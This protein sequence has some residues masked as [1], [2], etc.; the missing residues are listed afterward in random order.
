MQNK[1]VVRVLAI[2]LALVSLFY[3]SFSVVTGYYSNKAVEYAGGNKMKEYQYL[4][5]LS[6]E[7]VYLGYTLKECRE[8]EINLGLDLKGGMN[9]TL[10]VSV[11]D[12]LRVLSGYNNSPE[13]VQALQKTSELQKT[14]SQQD[15]LDLFVKTFEEIN[16]GG[17]L[18]SVFS[19][20]E[21]KEQ[22]SLKS[23]NAEVI[24]VLRGEIDAAISNS[25]NVLRTRIDRFGVVQPNIQRDNNNV[26]RIIIELPGVKEP[27][28]VRKLLQGSAN[29]EFWETFDLIEI[30]NNLME[31][32]KILAS[33]SVVKDTTAAVVADKAAEAKPKAPVT[34]QD[35]LKA[36]LKKDKAVETDSVKL[37]Q[38][39]KK[40]HPLLAVL[41]IPGI[42]TGQ[43]SRGPV[44]GYA[45]YKDTA[46]I[47]AYF[48]QRAVKEVLPANLALKWTVKPINERGDIYQLIAIKT[49]RN[50]R[51]PLTGESV[52]DARADFAQTS[53]YANVSMSMNNEGAKIWGR[54]TKENI[55]K[56]IAI[57]LDGYIYSFPTVNGE[58]TGGQSQITGN[59]TV[60]EAKDLANTLKSGKMP[61]PA[62]IIQEDVVGPTLG[63]DAINSGLISFLIA[64]LVVLAYMMF[65]YGFIPGLI[66][67]IALF[68]NVFF[69]I[70]ILASFSAVLTLPGIAGIVLTL[71][72][73][74]DGNVLIY[75]RIK[76]E[77]KGGKTMKKAIE[78]GFKG[79]ISAIIDANVT[80]LITGIVLAVF[81]TGP[82]K[83][84]ANTLIIG[85]ITSF[86]T[87]VFLTRLM[88]E[89]YA[90]KNKAKDLPFSTSI[91][92]GWFQNA[93]LNFL[94]GRRVAYII[95]GTLIAISLVS[96]FTKGFSLG[97]DFSGGRNYIVRFDENVKPENVRSLL[98]D[99]FDGTPVTVITIGDENQ[100][101]ITTKYKIDDNSEKVDAEIEGLLYEGL[102]PLLKNT[103]KQTFVDSNIMSSQKVGPTIAD[104]I[105]RAAVWAILFSILAIGL[106]I[107]MRFR[108]VSY[109][110]GAVVA[111]AHDAII[112][113][114][115]FS[116]LWDILPFS[117]EIDQ[118]FIAAILTVIGYS[119]NDTV[120]VFDRIRE[121][122]KLYPKRD[123]MTI[124]N[125]A[126]N[127]TLSRTFSTSFSTLIVLIIIFIFGG[128]TIRGFVFAMLFGITVGTY[129]SIFI[130]SP[131]TYEF[132]KRSLKKADK[133]EVKK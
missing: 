92:K 53:A 101:R 105:K 50:N 87:A 5:S 18:A 43:F 106:Y 107:L 82:I 95:S 45:H 44:V 114:G 28:R 40:D 27:E 93:K 7:K 11:A 9:V 97:V 81:G 60:E 51:A 30:A 20:M 91:T 23:T 120:I 21:L 56:S 33:G 73:A 133:D 12:I 99:A 46:T 32:D 104:D 83:G 112:T 69:L 61:A 14:N 118:S 128:E 13:F 123:R 67:D 96:F 16:P 110:M 65:Y 76:E 59:F 58:I 98:A 41:Q 86:I 132:Y 74:V 49:N 78:D 102:K 84:F 8:K 66:A 85:I 15:Y 125:D 108:N 10:E 24:A 62:R 117:M 37:Q 22:I 38:Q 57:A 90:S 94:G 103:S 19:T 52:T 80:T 17:Q 129:S 34:K 48:A 47:N 122:I 119:V 124:M 3:L 127:N 70:G 100:V 36:A 130:A 71:G 79:A 42:E 26:G 115:V 75:E 121:Y 77:L 4:D 64:F 39:F 1:G 6:G 88:L 25:F 55:N 35:S 116:L 68:I 111:L 63:Q 72:M 131:I 113:L 2:L 89:L 126:I 54:M 31:A 29:L 109:S